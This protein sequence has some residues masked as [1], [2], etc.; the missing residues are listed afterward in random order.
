M[1]V[2][3]VYDDRVLE[4]VT[5]SGMQPPLFHLQ[6]VGSH[7]WKV[8]GSCSSHFLLLWLLSVYQPFL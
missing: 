4:A 3:M 2:A 6:L 1:V 7:S 5:A 8:L